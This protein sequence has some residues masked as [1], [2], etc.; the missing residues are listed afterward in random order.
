MPA[1]AVHGFVEKP[2]KVHLF[3]DQQGAAYN[4][5]R[6]LYADTLCMGN[7]RGPGVLTTNVSSEVTCKI[8]LQRMMEPAYRRSA[9]VP[10]PP[11]QP[12]LRYRQNWWGKLILQVAES[13]PVNYDPADPG[14][15]GPRNW[16]VRWRDAQVEDLSPG[17]FL[18]R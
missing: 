4:N 10:V 17:V 7:W 1:P 12:K 15:L 18:G 3:K 16:T 11:V 2:R 9:K 5:G 13:V 8:C 6:T 14:D